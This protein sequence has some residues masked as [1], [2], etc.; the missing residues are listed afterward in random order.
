MKGPRGMAETWLRA[1]V[2]LVVLHG[3]GDT[4][5]ANNKMYSVA[6]LLCSFT[7]FFLKVSW[8]AE[9]GVERGSEAV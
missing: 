8:E 3:F 5:L 7:L 4:S 1:L 9:L 2:S 6:P